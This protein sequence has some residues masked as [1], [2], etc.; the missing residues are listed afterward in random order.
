MPNYDYRCNTCCKRF[1]VFLSYQEYG[2]KPVKCTFCQSS[3]VSR[4]INRVRFARSLEGEL[5]NLADSD[6]LDGLEKDP[7]AL[8]RM[9]REMSRE[10]GE[11]L[12]P[13][14]DEV[15]NRLEKGEDPDQIAESMP[16]LGSDDE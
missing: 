12:G 2:I 13:E 11:D 8:G 16:D 3:N 4:L 6:D 10:T 14:F 9:M 7:K 15:V 5:D 1:S